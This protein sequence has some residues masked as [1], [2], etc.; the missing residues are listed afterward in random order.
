MKR[1]KAM[2][3]MLRLL[4]QIREAFFFHAHIDSTHPKLYYDA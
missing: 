1:E 4:R 3:R 2:L